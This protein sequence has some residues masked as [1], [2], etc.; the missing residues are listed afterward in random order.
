MAGNGP[1]AVDLVEISD[2]L[3]TQDDS[4]RTIATL[5]GINFKVSY[6]YYYQK[7]SQGPSRGPAN[8]DPQK[9]SLNEFNDIY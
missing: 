8:S 2:V 1:E 3:Q 5:L 6:C 7:Q 9:R 4:R